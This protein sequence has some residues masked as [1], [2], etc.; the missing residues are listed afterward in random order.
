[1]T[2][3]LIAIFLGWLGGYRF[4]KKQWLLGFIYL[5]TCGIAGIGWIIDI[6]T[7]ISDI[8]KGPKNLS[9]DCEITGGWAES[10]KF[11]QLKRK[12]ILQSVPVG[13]ELKVE[14]DFYQGAPYF[15]ICAPNGSDLGAM[16]ADLNKMIRSQY[17]NARISAVLTDKADPEHAQMKVTIHI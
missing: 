6:I 7:A 5:F 16:P 11:P 3:L 1:M 14:S 4:Y 15:L 10:K 8:K 17:P 13:S 9:Y 2:G 12:E